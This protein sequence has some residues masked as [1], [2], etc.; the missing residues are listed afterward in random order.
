[1]EDT[2][3][4]KMAGDPALPM[5]DTF[6]AKMADDPVLAV[7]EWISSEIARVTHRYPSSPFYQKDLRTKPD[8]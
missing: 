2:F 3:S 1:M 7:K 6:S 5:E 8:C 4:A